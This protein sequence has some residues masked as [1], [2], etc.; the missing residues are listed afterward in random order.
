MFRLL[1]LY[2]RK[3]MVARRPPAWEWDLWAG[4]A[5]SPVFFLSLDLTPA[6]TP[7]SLVDL[8]LK[9]V[10]ISCHA[11]CRKCVSNAQQPLREQGPMRT[12]SWKGAAGAAGDGLGLVLEV[13]EL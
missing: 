8:C 4:G 2:Y 7:G 12:G 3:D 11:P 1:A 6:S 9:A 5:H 13:K 10:P